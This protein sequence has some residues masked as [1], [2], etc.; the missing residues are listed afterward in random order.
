MF[1]PIRQGGEQFFFHTTNLKND[2]KLHAK[3]FKLVRQS[4]LD[5]MNPASKMGVWG[6]APRTPPT[7]PCSPARSLQ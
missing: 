3:S 7:L 4:T 5:C 6:T 1:A 2:S